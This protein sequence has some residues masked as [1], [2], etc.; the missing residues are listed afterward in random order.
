[1][2][3][4]EGSPITRGYLPFAVPS[5]K[6]ANV[7]PSSGHIFTQSGEMSKTGHAGV[8]V[9]YYIG[10][11][12]YT[13]TTEDNPD[14]QLVN[15]RAL[16]QSMAQ[17]QSPL[18]KILEMYS[19]YTVEVCYSLHVCTRSVNLSLTCALSCVCAGYCRRKESI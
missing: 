4:A 13:D 3:W 1:M 6:L 11:L 12:A 7:D 10:L 14:Q 16:A 19:C 17:W 9:P 5:V 2:E 18:V 8:G 15:T